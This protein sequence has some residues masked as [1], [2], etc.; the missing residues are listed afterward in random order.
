MILAYLKTKTDNVNECTSYLSQ[1]LIQLNAS[2]ELTGLLP[3]IQEV[4]G[5]NTGP[6][7]SYL[8]Y[9]R[10]LHRYL[11]ANAW[12]A[13]IIGHDRFLSYPLIIL[14]FDIILESGYGVV[15]WTINTKKISSAAQKTW[16]FR[17]VFLRKSTRLGYIR[18]EK[19]LIH[20]HN[21]RIYC[22]IS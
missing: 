20:F 8:D 11:Q 7:T 1:Q 22:D 4:Q 3:R 16:T 14:S 9:F 21:R 18:D 15:Q 5:S 2:V 19:L 13:S 6:Q 12:I 10:V 17:K